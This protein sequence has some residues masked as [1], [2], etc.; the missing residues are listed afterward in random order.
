MARPGQ[1]VAGIALLTTLLFVTA[2]G[3]GEQRADAYQV[4]TGWHDASPPSKGAIVSF[5]V[6]PDVPGLIVACTAER[7]G[8]VVS[9]DLGEGLAKVGAPATTA[10]SGSTSTCRNRHPAVSWRS[11]LVAMVRSLGWLAMRS[12]SVTMLGIHGTQ[13]SRVMAT[14]LAPGSIC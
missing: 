9:A 7:I 5:T 13:S 10:H 12:G 3:L 1:L 2:C 8:H 6:S 14:T 4:P 11:P